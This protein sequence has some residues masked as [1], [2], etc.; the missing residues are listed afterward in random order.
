MR[1]VAEL[2]QL[3]LAGGIPCLAYSA[4]GLW[5]LRALQ[6]PARGAE[7]AAL[8]FVFGSG[9]ASLVLLILYGVGIRVPLPA[10]AALALL[11]LPVLRGQVPLPPDTSPAPRWSRGVDALTLCAGALLCL[12]ALGPETY[13]DGFEYHLP[14]AKA[15]AEGGIRPLPGVVDAELRAGIDL[16]YGPALAAGQPDAAASVSACFT[17]ALAALVRAEAG[18]R[19]SPGAGSLAGLFVLLA[20]L[21]LESAPSSYVDFGAGA[22]GFLALAFADRWNRTG[23][24]RLI[25]ATALCL[26]FAANAKLN[27]AL[28]SPAVFALVLLGGRPPR[29]RQLAGASALV[30]ALVIPWSVKVGLTTGNPFF[31]LFGSLFGLGG[32]HAL[33]LDLRA[34]RLSIDFQVARTPIGYVAYLMSL[35]RGF[36][37]HGSRLLGPL[38]F[39]LAPFALSRLP[40]ATT[41]L[42]VVLF[43]LAILQFVFM[44]ALRFA[45]PIL[46][47]VA[48]A[49]AVGGARIARWGRGMQVVL[50]VG[51]FALALVQA[52]DLGRAYL[53]RIAALRD[54]RAYERLMFPDQDALRETVA[55]ATPVVA[56]PKGAVAWMP[57]PV[58]V[59]HWERNGE[60]FFDRVVKFQTTPAAAR[61]LLVR[62][63]V[64]SLVLDA[65]PPLPT[66]GTLGHPTVDVW[67]RAGRARV[68]DE[69]HRLPARDG[70][71]WVTIDLL[72]E[73]ATDL[74]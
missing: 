31:P 15:W 5:L 25:P 3:A 69:P 73:P 32:Y 64:R 13:W 49:A 38:P 54:P 22:Y 40:R 62:R 47:F 45:T 66:D 2:L 18:R 44:P 23:D 63:G 29:A 11:G 24:T 17:L 36:N 4:L 68:R 27:L 14:I 56:I 30:L 7:R 39:L 16:L 26:A 9:A 42:L 70:R 28:L 65:L 33:H 6:L 34:I 21:T 37:P 10:L 20:P 72:D 71:V 59:L 51:L 58:Y 1:G 61:A 43:A 50:A 67:I 53:P 41:L 46:P 60:L 35:A 55:R 19:A 52:I 48:I 8:A 12:A 57:K 74:R